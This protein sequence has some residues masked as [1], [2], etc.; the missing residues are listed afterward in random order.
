MHPKVGDKYDNGDTNPILTD[1]D[2]KELEG[3][4][5]SDNNADPYDPNPKIPELETFTEA[6]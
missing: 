1:M 5:N 2:F 6:T 3:K 4:H